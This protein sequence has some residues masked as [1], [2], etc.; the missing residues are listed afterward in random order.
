[1]EGMSMR[2]S[3]SSKEQ[4]VLE[5]IRENPFVSQQELS[6]QLGLSRS[7]VAYHISALARKGQIVGRAYILPDRKGL[8]CIG[9]ANVDRKVRLHGP[10]RPGTSNPVRG[11]RTFGGVA[12]NIAENLA[13]AG[14]EVSLLTAVGEDRDGEAILD[15]CRNSGVDVSLS[16]R[17]SGDETGSYTAVLEPGGEMA[18]A[19]A[20]MEVL[21][22][23]DPSLLERLWPRIRSVETVIADTNLPPETLEELIRRCREDGV[24]LAIVP[25][26]VPKADRL[27]KDLTGV[28]VWVGNADEASEI[29]GDGI[30]E[31]V[32]GIEACRMLRQ[33]GVRHVVLTR[34]EAGVLY[35]DEE[36]GEGALPGPVVEVVDVTGAGDAFAAGVIGS[37]HQ[38]SD[39]ETACRTGLRFAKATLETEASVAPG[40]GPGIWKEEGGKQ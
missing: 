29:V 18:L 40:L 35:A 33:R 27:P 20:D 8:V 25:V 17:W 37:L 3:L 39:L 13:R 30:R 34:G 11:M 10:L 22:R 9:G 28:T 5:L 4:Q 24:D 26:S 19:L 6:N 1:M 16:T 12:R 31:E 32:D 36:N 14:V 2:V 7:A 15:H 21:D 38:G 23:I